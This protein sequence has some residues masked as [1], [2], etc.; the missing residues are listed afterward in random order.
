VVVDALST[1]VVTRC[2]GCKPRDYFSPMSRAAYCTVLWFMF[3]VKPCS[4]GSIN[5][6]P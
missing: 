2:E 5:Q 4:A 3:S 1:E 6:A